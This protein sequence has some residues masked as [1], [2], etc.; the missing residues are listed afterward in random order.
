MS[1]GLAVLAG[2]HGT[3]RLPGVNSVV[4]R[5]AGKVRVVPENHEHN[6]ERSDLLYPPQDHEIASKAGCEPPGPSVKRAVLPTEQETNTRSKPIDEGG[7]GFQPH[8]QADTSFGSR[9]NS[10]G[11]QGDPDGGGSGNQ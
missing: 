9:M 5:I 6:G 7:C 3:G 4:R 8:R 10:N 2:P 11:I 1:I